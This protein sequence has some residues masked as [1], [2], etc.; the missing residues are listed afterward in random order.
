MTDLTF[1]STTAAAQPALKREILLVGSDGS[2]HE[3]FH[4]S[5]SLTTP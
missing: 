1:G 5:S 4:Y 3:F 2:Q